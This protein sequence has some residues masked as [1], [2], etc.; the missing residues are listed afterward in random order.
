MIYFAY[1]GIYCVTIGIDV[2]ATP[3][4]SYIFTIG[5]YTY[6]LYTVGAATIGDT[7]GPAAATRG[8]GG[9]IY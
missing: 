7:T 1:S 4:L 3:V 5:Y 2:L 8:A 6:W 9:T